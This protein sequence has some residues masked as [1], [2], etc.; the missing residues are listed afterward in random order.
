MKLG[1][2]QSKA[3]KNS[4]AF[5]NEFMNYEEDD[6]ESEEQSSCYYVD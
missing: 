3:I 1:Q 5:E 2:N 6:S 4:F